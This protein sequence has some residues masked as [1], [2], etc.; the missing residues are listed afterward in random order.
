MD[1]PFY[2]CTPANTLLSGMRVNVPIFMKIQQ[3]KDL[4]FSITTQDSLYSK[5]KSSQR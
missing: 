4:D 5:T 2:S 1:A 3:L